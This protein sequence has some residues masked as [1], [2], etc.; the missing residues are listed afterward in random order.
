MS[1]IDELF[2]GNVVQA[3]LDAS[4]PSGYKRT[5]LTLFALRDGEFVVVMG[6]DEEGS[7]FTD[8]QIQDIFSIFNATVDGNPDLGAQALHA[9]VLAEIGT[10]W[11]AC[12][13]SGDCPF[14]QTVEK[15]TRLV[16]HMHIPGWSFEDARMKFK[17][18]VPPDQFSCLTWL[19]LDGRPQKPNAFSIVDQDTVAG[20]FYYSLYARM[21]QGQHWTRILIDP[22]TGNNGMGP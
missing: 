10:R 19:E 6:I 1:S 9:K 5:S 13:P 18:A 15:S 12:A 20:E 16:Y 8:R 22:K 2:D 17:S 14:D 7:S 4:S 11:T 3:G 21:Q